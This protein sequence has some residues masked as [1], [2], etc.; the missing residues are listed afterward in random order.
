MKFFENY[1]RM[2]KDC[3]E[4]QKLGKENPELFSAKEDGYFIPRQDEIQYL[5]KK[6]NLPKYINCKYSDMKVYPL[7]LN[8]LAKYTCCGKFERLSFNEAWLQFY[9]IEVHKKRW[10]SSPQKWVRVDK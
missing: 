2:C 5:F 7:F 9:M 1:K 4:I 6:A 3:E 8:C 10:M